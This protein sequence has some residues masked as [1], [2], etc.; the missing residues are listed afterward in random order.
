MAKAGEKSPV[1]QQ[2]AN[3]LNSSERQEVT[4]PGTEDHEPGNENRHGS[5]R[6][7]ACYLEGKAKHHDH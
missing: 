4:R 1:E 6:A 2:M 7:G 5:L 3:A